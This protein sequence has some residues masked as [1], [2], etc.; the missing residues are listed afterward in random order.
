MMRGGD[1]NYVRVATAAVGAVAGEGVTLVE[2][3]V[4]GIGERPYRT[5]I[6]CFFVVYIMV[7]ID[8]ALHR[9][10]RRSK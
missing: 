7:P 2:F 3:V 8:N 6:S 9:R 4:D 1:G 10:K 5:K